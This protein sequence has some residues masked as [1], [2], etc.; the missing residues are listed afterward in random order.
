MIENSTIIVVKRQLQKERIQAEEEL[1]NRRTAISITYEQFIELFLIQANT[2]LR[3]RNE[4]HD[5]V[6]DKSNEN[7]IKDLFFYF[8]GDPRFNGHHYKGILLIG[9]YGVGKS[10]ILMSCCS[11]CTHLTPKNITIMHSLNLSQQINEKGFDFFV[12][13][14]MLIDDLGKEAINMKVFGTEIRPVVELLTHRYEMGTWTLAT[15]NNN[16]ESLAN[17]YGK[18]I[19]ER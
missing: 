15:S 11:I 14:P 10:L 7:L 13:R 8:S 6:I 12:Q 3:R 1:N 16:L 19:E 9:S 2:Y 4:T 5:F 17:F 18:T